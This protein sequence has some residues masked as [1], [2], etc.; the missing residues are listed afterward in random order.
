MRRRFIAL[1]PDSGQWRY[2][3]AVSDQQQASLLQTGTFD[4]KPD[5]S[6]GEQLTAQVGPLQFQDRLACALPA[7]SAMIRWLD[8][9]FSEPQKIA[10]ASRLEMARQLPDSSDG[11]V[12][13]QQLLGDNRVLAIAVDKKPLESLLDQFDDNREPLGYI[14]LAPFYHSTG[15]DEQEDALLLNSEQGEIS[16]ARYEQGKL[17]DLRILP[18]TTVTEADIILQHLQLLAHGTAPALTRL[19]LLGVAEDSQLAD[20]LR[21]A[22]F[23]IENVRLHTETGPVAAEFN[24]V[25]SLALAAAKASHKDLNLRS[26]EYKLKNDWQA[27]KRRMW[28]AVGLLTTILVTVIATG[29]L[30]YQQRA[31]ELDRLEQQMAAIYQQEFPGERLLVPAPLQLQSKLK[32]LQQKSRQFGSGSPGALELLLTVSERI[33]PKLSVDISEY[34]YNEDGLRLSGTTA[35]F[36]AVSRLLTNLQQETTFAEARI[37]DSKQAIDGSKVDFQLQIQLRQGEDLR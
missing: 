22:G 2:A 8:F 25:A 1:Q 13:Y 12:N 30:Q 7:S 33:D 31:G 5:I 19:R 36:D 14:G 21:E 3:V 4:L 18:Q 32:E 15:L 17:A 27:L 28:L 29:S 34:L 37:L 11:L 10:A 23:T 9:P 6:L 24:G 26:G 20:K 16:L 35:D